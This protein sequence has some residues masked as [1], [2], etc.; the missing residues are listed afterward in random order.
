MNLIKDVKIIGTCP[1]SGFINYR[2]FYSNGN[3]AVAKYTGSMADF[4]KYRANLL[5]M[6]NKEFKCK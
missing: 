2:V 3:S 4:E 1:I 6:Y 5:F